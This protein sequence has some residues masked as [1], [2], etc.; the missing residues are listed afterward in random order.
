MAH[1]N[2]GEKGK[3]R[4]TKT[5]RKFGRSARKVRWPLMP[6]GLT[7]QQAWHWYNHRYAHSRKDSTA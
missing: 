2:P 3:H 5:N 4:R 1:G 7:I 6:D